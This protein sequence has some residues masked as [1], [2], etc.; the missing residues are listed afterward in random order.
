M[1]REELL[2]DHIILYDLEN[3]DKLKA[4]LSLGYFI[5]C[6]D[7]CRG[8]YFLKYD[9]YTDSQFCINIHFSDLN[10]IE[11]RGWKLSDIVY[12]THKRDYC[13][14]YKIKDFLQGRRLSIPVVFINNLNIND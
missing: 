14:V 1:T 9:P 3:K 7:R 12:D 2:N 11:S 10:T 5:L 13:L 4:L 6:Y 8:I